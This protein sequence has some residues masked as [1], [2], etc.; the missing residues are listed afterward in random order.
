MMADINADAPT[1]QDLVDE[2][3]YSFAQPE[4]DSFMRH[5]RADD[6][7]K[8]KTMLRKEG[9]TKVQ[10][11]LMYDFCRKETIG[12]EVELI[13]VPKDQWSTLDQNRNYLARVG[14]NVRPLRLY[15][16]IIM[17]DQLRELTFDEIG[18]IWLISVKAQHD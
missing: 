16:S 18:Q 17:V 8:A 14:R 1:V 3:G 6:I 4:M 11:D 15:G 7:K 2:L 10:Q 12:E 5:V 9:Y 13:A